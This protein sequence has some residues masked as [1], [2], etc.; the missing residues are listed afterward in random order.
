MSRERAP[1]AWQRFSARHLWDYNRAAR[2]YWVAMVAA[3]GFALGAALLQLAWLP[4]DALL[5]VA[6]GL[7]CTVLAALL[8]VAVPGVRVS[9]VVGELF[10]F[11]LLLLHGMP[12]AVVARL[13]ADDLRAQ[14]RAAEAQVRVPRIAVGPFEGERA[15]VFVG[16]LARA[17]GQIERIDEA[18]RLVR[19]AD[20]RELRAD[21]VALCLGN[22]PPAALAGTAWLVRELNAGKFGQQLQRF[23]KG[24]L[25]VLFGERDDIAADAAAETL[26]DTFLR[27]DG[28]GRGFFAVEG[29]KAP[30][31][32][33]LP[34]ERHEAPN[35]VLY[36]KGGND[37]ICV[38]CH[39]LPRSR[40]PSG[41]RAN[42]KY[43]MLRGKYFFYE[44]VYALPD[45]VHAF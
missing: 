17:L 5:Q 33:T 9:F 8:P 36:G 28:K 45:R 41:R 40:R 21:R 10:I 14:L 42:S 38:G 43:I 1:N 25:V 18:G 22:L 44:S 31:V 4:P 3:G 15:A 26:V 12:A 37:A 27:G 23:D 19:L 34:L 30:K 16:E 35:V 24:E 20:G 11:V 29:T 7:A 6:A 32:V 2:W 13:D 39:A